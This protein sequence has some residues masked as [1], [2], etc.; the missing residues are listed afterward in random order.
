MLAKVINVVIVLLVLVG[1]G[2][3][4]LS[5]LKPFQNEALIEDKID[6]IEVYQAGAS[7]ASQTI[8][9]K[10]MIE[11]ILECMNTT[12]D[13]EEMSEVASYAAVDGS[14]LFFGTNDKY[15]VGIYQDRGTVSFVYDGTIIDSEFEPFPH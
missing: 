15:E 7:A 1:I 12:C 4:I 13:R 10:D 6:R 8:T 3:W 2:V 5:A 14:L 9:D 11:D